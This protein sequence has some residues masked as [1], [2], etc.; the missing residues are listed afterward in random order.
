MLYN[1]F[2]YSVPSLLTFFLLYLLTFLLIYFLTIPG[3]SFMS[4]LCHS[5]LR[6][7]RIIAFV[8]LVLVFQY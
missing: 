4:K 2:A 6:Y 8:V 7:G 1:S 3:F 5:I